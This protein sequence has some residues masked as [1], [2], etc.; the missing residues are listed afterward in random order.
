MKQTQSVLRLRVS[1][2][3]QVCVR[4]LLPSSLWGPCAPYRSGWGHPNRHPPDPKA[5]MAHTPTSVSCLAP[6]ISSLLPCGGRGAGKEVEKAA[7]GQGGGD[8]GQ[9]ASYPTEKN[10]GKLRCRNQPPEASRNNT[11]AQGTHRAPKST[12]GGQAKSNCGKIVENCGIAKNCGPD[13]PPP[14]RR[15][16]PLIGLL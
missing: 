14:W 1:Q 8:C 2:P 15:S 9:G 5:F 3:S 7:A 13:P 6:S 12:R 4:A 16:L 10:C 11:S